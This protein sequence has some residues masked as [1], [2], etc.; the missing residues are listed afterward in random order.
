MSA[1]GIR[2]LKNN[3]SEYIRQVEKGKRV[4][5]TSHGRIVAE[6]VPPGTAVG[7]KRTLPV[8]RFDRLVADGV[9]RPPLEEGDPLEDDGVRICLPKGT[10]Q[11]LTDWDRSEDDGA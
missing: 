4:A 7:R 9:I 2:E 10:V 5:V 1:V 3:L 8:S 6:L 11:E